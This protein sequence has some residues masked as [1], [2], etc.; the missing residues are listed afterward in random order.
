VIESVDAD[1]ADLLGLTSTGC[2]GRDLIQ[3]FAKN[4]ASV[5]EAIQT[6]RTGGIVRGSGL[7]RP[8]ERKPRPVTFTVGPDPEQESSLKWVF[9]LRSALP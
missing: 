6:A 2:R 1:G 7:I 3:F 5:I 9:E 8:R 4:R